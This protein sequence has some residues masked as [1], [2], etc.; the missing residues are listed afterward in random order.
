[1]ITMYL[2][3]A[4]LNIVQKLK[5]MAVY[6]FRQRRESFKDH[7]VCDAELNASQKLKRMAVY[8]FLYRTETFHY[9]PVCD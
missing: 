7:P 6:K 2:C 3:D 4:E 9:H 5:R 8:K 1:M